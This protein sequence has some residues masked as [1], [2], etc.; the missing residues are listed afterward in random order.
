MTPLY[1]DFA[2]QA[3]I[4]AQY[5]PALGLPDALAPARRYAEQ[6]ASARAQLL[7][8]GFDVQ[9]DVSYGPTRAETL[10]IFAAAQPGAPVFVFLHGGYWRALSARDFSTVALGLLPLG[11]TT[12]VVNYAL[13]PQVSIDEI[14]RQARAA[15][16]WT[17]RQI[18][19]YGGDPTRVAVGGH[20]AGAQLAAMCLLTDWEQDYGLAPDPLAAGLMLSGLYDLAP[21]RYSYLQP[22]IQLDAGLI[23]RQSPLRQ[24]RRCRTPLAIHWGERESSEFARQSLAFHQAWQALGNLSQVSALTQADHYQV[25][26][27]LAQAD[28]VLSRWLAQRLCN[29]ASQDP[30]CALP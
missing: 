24:M 10:D 7:N 17:L 30:A 28:D 20:S 3:Q 29:N 11:I 6:A 19:H 27:G 2:T 14:T 8:G 4:D 23:E 22:L 12:V 1:R 13:C 26:D 18:S 15:V 5:N 16:A 9:L 21:L 25:V